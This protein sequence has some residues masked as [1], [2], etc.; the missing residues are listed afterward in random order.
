VPQTTKPV[1]AAGGVLWRQ[2]DT[3]LEVAVIHRERYD[4]W[5][6]PKGKVDPGETLPV[7]A[8][9]EIF[10]ETGIRSALGRRLLSVSYP[11]DQGVK[12]VWYWS[13]RA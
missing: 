3:G 6:L 9:R 11:I 4:D 1:L 2:G 5:S 10:E 8:V 13:A 7:T 12:K